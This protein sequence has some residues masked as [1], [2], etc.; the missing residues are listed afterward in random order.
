MPVVC[1]VL[2]WGWHCMM[3]E[4]PPASQKRHDAGSGARRPGQ[5]GCPTMGEQP[6]SVSPI[7]FRQRALI[8]ST[9][10][11]TWG[12]SLNRCIEVTEGHYQSSGLARECG[13]G[14]GSG[15]GRRFP[16]GRRLLVTFDTAGEVRNTHDLGAACACKLSLSV[17]RPRAKM[18]SPAVVMKSL[19]HYGSKSA[20][21]IFT[22]ALKVSQ[23]LGGGT[24]ASS[25][26][27]LWII[28]QIDGNSI[29]SHI[30][31]ASI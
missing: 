29:S 5:P 4:P 2:A 11:N 21:A 23:T 8:H 17:G 16:N 26:G 14:D 6:A 25:A 31:L 10:R 19:H 3:V 15:M 20:R 28:Y 9:S 13:C 24:M 18:T 27:S 1:P 30:M 12:L 22:S 7:A